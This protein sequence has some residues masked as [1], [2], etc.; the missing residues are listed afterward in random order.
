M[1]AAE[2]WDVGQHQGVLPVPAADSRWAGGS[3]PRSL[4]QPEGEGGPPAQPGEEG[5]ADLRPILS[6]RLLGIEAELTLYVIIVVRLTSKRL[7][8]FN[9]ICSGRILYSEGYH[10]Y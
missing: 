1:D 7:E 3:S 9:D 2:A 4:A 6:L 10:K 8:I 5:G